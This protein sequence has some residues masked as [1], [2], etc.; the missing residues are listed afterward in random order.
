[1]SYQRHNGA[2]TSN[3]L[4]P[5]TAELTGTNQEDIAVTA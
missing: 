4:Y 1:M 5:G 3:V 2:G